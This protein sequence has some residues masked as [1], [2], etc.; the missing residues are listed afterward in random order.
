MEILYED[1][2]ILAVNK[3]AGTPAQPDPSGDASVLDLAK[4]YIKEKYAKPGNVFLAL[5]HR[6]DRPVGGV[7]LFGRTSK[8]ARRLGEQFQQR[9]IQKTYWAVVRGQSSEGRLLHYLR[10]HPKLENTVKIF[11][12]PAKDA[13]ECLLE[14]RTLA[15]RQG[16]SWVEVRPLTG[17]K[18]QIR[19][20]LAF[21]KLP[22]VGDVKYGGDTALDNR[23]V[24]LF[25]RSITVV[26]P[27]LRTTLQIVAR[28][29][30]RYPWNFFL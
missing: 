6:L 21:V 1:S 16:L 18:H 12:H 30:D 5:V 24:A 29:P 17:R 19:A 4:A 11:A 22:I 23:D 20:Q 27:T 2:Q 25:A 13:K 26:H 9:R 3:P 8:A 7:M 10:P 28:P 15:V 14:Y